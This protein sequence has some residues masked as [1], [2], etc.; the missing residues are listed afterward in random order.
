MLR[1]T[2]RAAAAAASGRR[3][4]IYT[5]I[6]I[7]Q[8]GRGERA[9][10]IFSRLLRER[11]VCLFGPIDDHLASLVCAQLLFL[12]SSAPSSP[13]SLYINSPGG[14]VTSGLAICAPVALAP[15]PSLLARCPSVLTTRNVPPPRRQ[16]TQCSTSPAP[17]PRCA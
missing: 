7:E 17:S 16:T 11:V 9:F 6:V 10:D 2:A 4:L 13:I 14:A 12:E 15:R 3:S 8:S 5:P 1:R